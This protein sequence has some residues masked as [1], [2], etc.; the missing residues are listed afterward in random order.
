MVHPALGEPSDI[1]RSVDCGY[2]KHRKI[3][4]RPSKPPLVH[5]LGHTVT[6]DESQDGA[7]GLLTDVSLLPQS[8]QQG[9]RMLMM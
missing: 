3:P 7:V 9:H 8:S 4:S 2:L 5:Y 6:C 1:L